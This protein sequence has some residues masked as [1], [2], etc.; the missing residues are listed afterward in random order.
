MPL[1]YVWHLWCYRTSDHRKLTLL[2]AIRSSRD[3]R[4]DQ[5]RKKL[6][7]LDFYIDHVAEGH[8]LVINLRKFRIRPRQRAEP[9]PDTRRTPPDND[10]RRAARATRKHSES[11]LRGGPSVFRHGSPF[12]FHLSLRTLKRT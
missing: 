4:E 8:V 9:A 3:H 6:I 5:R 10:A 12:L 2:S 7:T 11:I 1:S